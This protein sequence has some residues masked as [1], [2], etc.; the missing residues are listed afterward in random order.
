MYLWIINMLA[1]ITSEFGGSGPGLQAPPSFQCTCMHEKGGG[2]RGGEG[3]PGN[4]AISVQQWNR[5]WE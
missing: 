1:I 5:V 4:E 3:V 2:G